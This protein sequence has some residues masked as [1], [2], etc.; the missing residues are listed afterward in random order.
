MATTLKTQGIINDPAILDSRIQAQLL[1]PHKEATVQAVVRKMGALQAQH[2]EMAQWA[3]GKR[4]GL[5]PHSAKLTARDVQYALKKGHIVRTHALRPTWQLLVAED[6]LWILQLTGPQIK[7]VLFARDRQVGVAAKEYVRSDE[8][9]YQIL[10]EH[11][12]LSRQELIA[13]LTEKGFEMNEYRSMHY[14]M[15]AEQQGIICSGPLNNEK[16]TYA[17]LEVRPGPE[18]KKSGTA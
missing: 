13:A 18:F 2:L 9:I 14:I 17:L 15:H 4:L 11:P 3:I 10:S 1:S 16:H 12:H 5:C 7:K 8:A 6:L